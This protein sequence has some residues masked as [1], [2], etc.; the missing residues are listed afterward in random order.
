MLIFPMKA[1]EARGKQNIRPRPCVHAGYVA[2]TERDF[3]RQRQAEGI[4][5]A[6]A[7][8]VRFGRERTPP[9]GVF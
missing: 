5:A 4:Q 6:K 2:Q 1:R 9:A 7:R 3:M 8:G